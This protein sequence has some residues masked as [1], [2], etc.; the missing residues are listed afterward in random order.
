MDGAMPSGRGQSR[1]FAPGPARQRCRG[2]SCEGLPYLPERGVGQDI[3]RGYASKAAFCGPTAGRWASWPT[4]PVG[5]RLSR[6]DAKAR[7]CGSRLGDDRVHSTRNKTS[8]TLC[9]RCALDHPQGGSY[10]TPLLQIVMGCLIRGSIAL[11]PARIWCIGRCD[12]AKG[13]L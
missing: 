5:R 10:K 3:L 9:E 6:E 1:L 8:K 12:G 2:Q 7:R 11:G 13:F 4:G